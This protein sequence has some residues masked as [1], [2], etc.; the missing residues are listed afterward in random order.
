MSVTATE[1]PHCGQE[2]NSDPC[3]HCACRIAP[4]EEYP[5]RSDENMTKLANRI[6]DGWDY[7]E[8]YQYAVDSLFFSYTQDEENYQ[9][10]IDNLTEEEIK[11]MF[12]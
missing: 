2:S 9:D 12:G 6:V 3:E 5:E 1:C 4:R 11:K 7:K 8:I 10:D